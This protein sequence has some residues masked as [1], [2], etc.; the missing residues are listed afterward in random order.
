MQR[1]SSFLPTDTSPYIGIWLCAFKQASQLCRYTCSICSSR[2]RLVVSLFWS[3]N[4]VFIRID[5]PRYSCHITGRAIYPASNELSVHLVWTLAYALCSPLRDATGALIIFAQWWCDAVLQGATL[6]IFTPLSPLTTWDW[7]PQLSP[8]FSYKGPW[9]RKSFLQRFGYS[10]L[11]L[12]L[13]PV[14]GNQL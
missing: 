10:N 12:V 13:Y 14:S 6:N 9:F 1:I 11:L 5:S 2:Q 7:Y 8:N 4:H 3:F